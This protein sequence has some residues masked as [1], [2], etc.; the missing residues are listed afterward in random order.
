M[1]KHLP[2]NSTVPTRFS[3]SGALPS[4]CRYKLMGEKEVRKKEAIKILSN[5]K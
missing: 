5:K 2:V 4:L 3:I 1:A